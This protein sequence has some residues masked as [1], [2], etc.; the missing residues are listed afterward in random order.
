[1]RKNLTVL[2][3]L[4]C[5]ALQAQNDQQKSNNYYQQFQQDGPS[6]EP[7][8]TYVIRNTPEQILEDLNR[9]RAKLGRRKLKYIKEYQK[10]LDAWAS[11]MAK[12]DRLFHS[13]HPGEVISGGPLYL[14]VVIP[15]FKASPGHWKVLMRRKMKGVCIGVCQTPLLNKTIKTHNGEMTT[16]IP[17]ILYTVIRV[18]D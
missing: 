18:Y 3:M 11:K 5:G 12:A 6:F 16:F 2:L 7:T 17:G 1:M 15:G 4:L 14:T 9:E 10:S 13:G 8:D